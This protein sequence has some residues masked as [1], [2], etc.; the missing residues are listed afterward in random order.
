[1]SNTGWKAIELSEE[2]KKAIS[3]LKEGVVMAVRMRKVNS[4]DENLPKVQ[5]EFAEKISNGTRIKTAASMFNAKD[6]RFSSGAQRVWETADLSI[7]ES[8]FGEIPEGQEFIE[9]LSTMDS[10]DGEDFRI[11]LTEDVESSLT[12]NETPYADNYLK[13]AGRDG[14]YFYTPSGDRVISRKRLVQVESGTNPV[15]TY[16]SGK[17][18]NEPEVDAHALVS[19]SAT[20]NSILAQV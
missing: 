1:M 2:G 9:I 16:L 17:F 13:R 15:N 14:Q 12:E 6:A 4:S 18:G 11:Q 5:I 3:T 20:E 7:A 19:K 8:M 10:V